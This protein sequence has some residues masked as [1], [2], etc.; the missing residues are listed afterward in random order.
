M[1]L[2][3]QMNVKDRY[4]WDGSHLEWPLAV[5]FIPCTI[6]VFKKIVI[7]LI[8]TYIAQELESHQSPMI[9]LDVKKKAHN[10]SNRTSTSSADKEQRKSTQGQTM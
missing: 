8:Q 3:K 5:M 4:R 2:A 7:K 1:C 9:F 6:E 10:L